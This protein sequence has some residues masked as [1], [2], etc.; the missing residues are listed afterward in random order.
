M[1]KPL[2]PGEK[3]RARREELGLSL[4]EVHEQ[5]HVP[6]EYIRALEA[7]AVD[8]LPTYTYSLGFINSYCLFLELSP[9]PYLS[10]FRSA[11]H[12]RQQAPVRREQFTSS[13]MDRMPRAPW[14]AE[15]IAWGAICGLIIL[16]WVAYSTIVKPLAE[17]GESRVEAGEAPHVEQQDQGP[18]VHFQEEE[19]LGY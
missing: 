19:Y 8:K 4:A 18:L 12:K 5:I 13:I 1:S 3:L 2:F 7:G 16:G 14:M 6:L 15:L 10:Y 9:E 17:N 11:T